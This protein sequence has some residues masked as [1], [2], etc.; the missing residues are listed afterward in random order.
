MNR[1]ILALIAPLLAAV[2][3]ANVGTTAAAQTKAEPADIM[4]GGNRLSTI[5]NYPTF[6]GRYALQDKLPERL[7]SLT[8]APGFDMDVAAFRADTRLDRDRRMRFL[9][10]YSDRLNIRMAYD[11]TVY[12]LTDR[13]LFDRRLTIT[14][15][16][17]VCR[18][19]GGGVEKLLRSIVCFQESP[20]PRGSHE[21]AATAKAMRLK[22]QKAPMDYTLP[23]GTRRDAALKL[24]DAALVGALLN[25]GQYVMQAYS[26]LPTTA[27]VDPTGRLDRMIAETRAVPG[28]P[29]PG[30][31][32]TAAT[33]LSRSLIFRS[34]EPP[35]AARSDGDDRPFDRTGVPAPGERITPTEAGKDKIR[36]EQLNQMIKLGIDPLGRLGLDGAK[37]PGEILDQ[38]GIANLTPTEEGQARVRRLFADALPD[39]VTVPGRVENGSIDMLTG[40][41]YGRKY[42][43]H[44]GHTFYRG[45]RVFDP[46]FVRLTYWFE[47]ILTLKAPFHGQVDNAE[48][49]FRKHV[50]GG[51][52]V[53]YYPQRIDYDLHVTGQ[54]VAPNGRDVFTEVGLARDR[55]AGG[56]EFKIGLTADAT[57]I[58]DIPGP[59]EKRVYFDQIGYSIQRN[60][61]PPLGSAR[62][63]MADASIDGRHLGLGVDIGIASAEVDFGLSLFG[64]NGVLTATAEAS[65]PMYATTVSQR[66]DK[67]R[68]SLHQPVDR[69][70]SM[71]RPT[72]TLDNPR[73]TVDMEYVPYIR[74]DIRFGVGRYRWQFGDPIHI[75]MLTIR[76]TRVLTAHDGTDN[77]NRV[78]FPLPEIL[79]N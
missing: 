36:R 52:Q 50:T 55:W 15:D 67:I 6:A 4:I 47:P 42:A 73:Y 25:S 46:I 59:D 24:S 41:T 11:D 31:L 78:V 1:R 71:S 70:V 26:E 40:F 43:G 58:Y 23:D 49:T 33:N 63:R 27:L 30:D 18:S 68:A 5:L 28:V 29:R 8:V 48:W 2:A 37:M 74:P 64:R 51:G 32:D 65:D 19:D 76:D 12:D 56:H 22:L 44:I 45:D 72:L 34:P 9:D 3:G 54:D 60:F 14:Y 35:L 13:L 62:T 69:N 21:E 66:G 16:P 57:L 38:A 77:R 79:E 20:T 10:K 75:D 53:L 39:Q 7:Q 61:A 17:K